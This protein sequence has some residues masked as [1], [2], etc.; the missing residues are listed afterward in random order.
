MRKKGQ[1]PVHR[2][3]ILYGG[4]GTSCCVT[5]HDKEMYGDF[6]LWHLEMKLEKNALYM[7]CV[8]MYASSRGEKPAVPTKWP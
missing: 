5:Q 6:K 4:L 3:P 8:D 7:L 2:Q 1:S